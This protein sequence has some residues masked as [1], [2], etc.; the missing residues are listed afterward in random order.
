MTLTPEQFNMLATKDDLKILEEEIDQKLTKKIDA[1]LSAVDSIAKKYQ[2]H[3]SEHVA[4]LGAHDRM[5]ND[6][7]ECRKKLNLKTVPV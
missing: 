6:I 5:Q 7:N 1:V 4:N 3:E 2:D